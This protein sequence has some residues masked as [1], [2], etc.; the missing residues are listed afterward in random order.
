VRTYENRRGNFITT[1]LETGVVYR[2]YELPRDVRLRSTPLLDREITSYFTDPKTNNM[3]IRQI[4]KTDMIA[5]C[6]LAKNQNGMYIHQPR[7]L[8]SMPYPKNERIYLV[9]PQLP[10]ITISEN[11]IVPQLNI[12]PSTIPSV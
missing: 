4:G 2:F 8:H 11:A 10:G 1:M 3:R 5:L 12:T 7:L 6:V 9:I